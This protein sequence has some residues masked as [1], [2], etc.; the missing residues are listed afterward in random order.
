MT[1]EPTPTRARSQ[2]PLLRI[3]LVAA[4][5]LLIALGLLMV[6]GVWTAWTTQ[7]QL[8]FANEWEMPL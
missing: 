4:V 5:V 7:L 8:W 1:D 6:T 3:L 2:R